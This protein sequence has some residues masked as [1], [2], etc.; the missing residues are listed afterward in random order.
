MLMERMLRRFRHLSYAE[1]K[2]REAT[3]NDPGYPP[4]VLMQELAQMTYNPNDLPVII[5]VITARL[6]DIQKSWRH[7]YK[8]LVLLD[9]ILKSGSSGVHQ[10]CARLRFIVDDLQSTSIRGHAEPSRNI[11]R[12][13]KSVLETLSTQHEAKTSPFCL[14]INKNSVEKI[15]ETLK[16]AP[17]RAETED[18]KNSWQY[19]VE[20]DN[21]SEK[22]KAVTNFFE[23]LGEKFQESIKAN[24][25]K[26]KMIPFEVDQKDQ[27]V[28]QI[29]TIRQEMHRFSRLQETSRQQGA[30][31]TQ[32]DLLT[33]GHQPQQHKAVLPPPPAAKP[34]QHFPVDFEKAFPQKESNPPDPWSKLPDSQPKVPRDSAWSQG[35]FE[36]DD[37]ELSMFAT[38]SLRRNV[39]NKLLNCTEA[40][41][42]VREATSNDPW[43]PCT[44]LMGEIAS[45]TYSVVT[46][47]EVMPIIWKRLTDEGRNWRHVYKGLVLLEYLIKNGSEKVLHQARDKIY[48][49]QALRN[50]RHT[51]NYRDYGANIREK[52]RQ[53][54]ALLTDEDKLKRERSHAFRVRKRLNEV[55]SEYHYKDYVTRFQDLRPKTKQ[56]EDL[57]VQLTIEISR[58]EARQAEHRKESSRHHKQ[59]KY[60]KEAGEGCSQKPPQ[61]WDTSFID[62]QEQQLF[63]PMQAVCP[64]P[65]APL[66][67]PP[68]PW[69]TENQV[70]E[71]EELA[72]RHGPVTEQTT[73]DL[74]VFPPEGCDLEPCRDLVLFQPPN[75]NSR[76]PFTPQNHQVWENKPLY[77]SSLNPF[78]T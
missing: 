55:P 40:Q 51:E 48:L 37:G 52:S 68:N 29:K 70:D 33:T 6:R 75:H 39:K 35:G 78:L 30:R 72:R 19:T 15:L 53:L 14:P 77:P 42:K 65:S 2:V 12:L 73:K 44:A 41:V 61:A 36:Q 69:S 18:K 59:T 63:P 17:S 49:I 7:T 71:F 67:E 43:G 62:D 11:R 31:K 24:D 3:S 21:K 10:Y 54:V 23:N 5:E 32:Q 50:F 28:G 74:I 26:T 47:L 66:Q 27:R 13:A 34:T 22:Q 1:S 60:N 16:I 8:S 20:R 9:Y 45:M 25:T 76:N 56:E 64:E 58:E 46:F 4:L 38:R 57:Q